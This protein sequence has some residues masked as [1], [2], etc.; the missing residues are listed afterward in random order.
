MKVRSSSWF[1]KAH[2]SRKVGTSTQLTSPGV[3]LEEERNNIRR[4]SLPVVWFKMKAEQLTVVKGH[5]WFYTKNV[6]AT[7]QD[8]R[9]E[10]MNTFDGRY[11]GRAEFRWNGQNMWAPERSFQEV[12]AAQVELDAY[13]QQ[14]PVIPAGYEGWFNINPK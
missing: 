8:L 9:D 2:D 7:V 10:F 6:D 12:S 5:L 11:G 1:V 4:V 13:L 14:G 3:E